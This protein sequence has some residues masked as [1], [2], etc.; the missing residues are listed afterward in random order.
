MF[1]NTENNLFIMFNNI[2][3]K[4]PTYGKIYKIIDFGRSIY[5]LTDKQCLAIA[6]I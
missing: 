2:T 1:V 6:F 5:K 4:V 3:Y